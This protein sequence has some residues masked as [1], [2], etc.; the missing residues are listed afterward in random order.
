MV[1][2]KE[3]K[4][5]L[6]YQ[7]KLVILKTIQK[8][9]SVRKTLKDFNIPRS[10][11]YKWKKAFDLGGELAL[12]RKHPV[13]SS[14]PN[15]IKPEVVDQVLRLRKEQQLGSW[16]IKWYLERYHDI[17]ISESS[18][19]RILKRMGVARLEKKASRRSL[20]SK[21]Y[22]KST[23]GHHVQIDVKVAMLTDPKG[24]SIKRFQYTAIDDATRIRALQIYSQQTQANA[25][26]FVD[27]V[28]Q[29]FPFR[30]KSIRT[31]RGHE[32]QAKFHWHVEDLG[33]EH[34]YIKARTPQLN[35]KVERSHLTDQNEF[36]QLL[37]YKDDV[38]LR[39][40]LA[41]WEDFYNFH[42]P[43]GAHRGQTPYE[44]LKAKLSQ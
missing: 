5:Y 1:I 29:K 32:F 27:Y 35:G 43:H 41:R 38:D 26:S 13:A 40:K 42:R 10:T 22:N 19:T 4:A 28:V 16:R 21:R 44:A 30:I 34:H 14:H 39:E 12:L 6:S 25:I 18:V 17:R 24:Q 9:G 31:D 7:K 20:H 11:Y 23:P 2:T 3:V 33:M 15:M 37:H 36:Y 8:Y